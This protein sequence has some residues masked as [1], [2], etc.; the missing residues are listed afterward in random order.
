[1]TSKVGLRWGLQETGE[2]GNG[3]RQR[4]LDLRRRKVGVDYGRS[5]GGGD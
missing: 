4:M 2:D 3:G 5:G 1:M